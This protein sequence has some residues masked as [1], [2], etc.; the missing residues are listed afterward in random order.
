M[1]RRVQ[2]LVMM[3][4][5]VVCSW[6]VLWP[7]V[8]V[9]WLVYGTRLSQGEAPD[10]AYRWHRRLSDRFGPWARARI[11]SGRA[12]DLGVDDIAGTEWPIFGAVF[13]LWSSESLQAQWSES[14]RREPEPALYARDA[15]IAA[16]DLIADPGHAHWV[17]MHWGDD[18]L[19]RE[20]LFYRMLLIGG[21]DSFEAL[22]GDRRHHA[23]LS[24]QVQ[25]LAAELDQ[26]PHGLLDDYPGQCYPVDVLMAYAV[27]ARAQRRMGLD[28]SGFVERGWRAFSGD[29]L[30]PQTG[31][32]A[33]SVDARTGAKL[34]GS[35][36]V[37]QS[38]MLTFASEL[39]PDRARVWY[40]RYVERHWQSLFGMEGFREFAPDQRQVD[41]FMFEID[42]GPVVFGF[43]TAAS[44]FGL[45]AA[46][47]IGANRQS[48][49]LMAEAVLGAWPLPNGTLLGPRLLSSLSDAPYL[50]EAAL[51]FNMTRRSLQGGTAVEQVAIPRSVPVALTLVFCF[52]LWTIRR[53][54]VRY[55]AVCRRLSDASRT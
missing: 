14:D 49:P 26:S 17:R 16:A 45:G 9:A 37:G 39:W 10:S 36:G 50:G 18:Y 23:I 52:G 54:V 29:R 48:V 21:L 12:G 8:E 2:W 44:A 15:L 47:T 53:A 55:Q 34:D 32:P 42:A 51:L 5:I 24:D 43:G 3:L 38:A 19:D 13:F 22:T 27:I 20:N 31:L 1:R 46:R 41:P 4:T 35:R 6:F 30:D 7:T 28:A 33:Y 25:S 40:G 11:E